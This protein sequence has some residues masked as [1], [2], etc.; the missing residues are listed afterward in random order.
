MKA[1]FFRTRLRFIALLGCC[2]LAARAH[3]Q[4]KSGV[5][6]SVISLP[7]GAGSIEGLG[8]SFEPQLNSGT[9]SYS[10]GIQVPPGVAG[11]APEIALTYNGGN[12]NG[13]VGI[14]WEIGFPAI[15][16]QTDKGIP[17]YT[18]AEIAGEAEDTFLFGGE[19]LVPL[20][21]GTYRCE[22]EASF[23]RFRKI[24]SIQGGAINAWEAT[25]PDGGRMV[26]GESA[27]Q[28]VTR[29][30]GD[31][32]AFADT[33]AWQLASSIDT[34]GNVIRYNYEKF[35]PE[36]AGVLYP[37]RVEYA[38]F[39]D[40]IHHRVEFTYS[41]DARFPETRADV[42]SDFRAGFE[43]RTSKLLR[44]IAVHTDGALVRR[45]VLGYTPDPSIEVVQPGDVELGFNLLRSLT[46]FDRSG[47]DGNYLPPVRF[48]YT[49]FHTQAVSGAARKKIGIHAARGLSG[50]EF[51]P[52][53]GGTNF[54]RFSPDFT[55]VC[56]INSDGLPDFISSGE[57]A[58]FAYLNTGGGVF[59]AEVPFTTSAADGTNQAN[60]K[61]L[62]DTAITLADL[63]GDGITDLFQKGATSDRMLMHRNLN[64]F[65][66]PSTLISTEV[67][68]W[69]PEQEFSTEYGTTAFGALDITDP[70]IR[71]IDLNFDKRTDAM[72]PFD[73]GDG[74]GGVEYLF[75]LPDGWT[76]DLLFESDPRLPDDWSP[77]EA[78][79]TG[80]DPAFRGTGLADLNGDRLIDWHT[81]AIVGDEVWIDYWPNANG[82]FWAARRA[83]ER[84]TIPQARADELRVIDVNADGLADLVRVE[85]LQLSYWINTGAD[86]WSDAI[87]RTGAPNY[88]AGLTVL[89]EADINGNG[90]YDLFWDNSLIDPGSLAPGVSTYMYFDFVGEVPPN[91]L[92]VI[93]NGIGLRTLI[94]YKSSTADYL[95]AHNA[96]HPWT[97]K[98][99]FPVMLIARIVSNVGLDLN[100]DGA[101]DEYIRDFTYRDGYYDSFEKEFRGFAFAEEIARGDDYD[102]NTGATSA[103]TGTVSAPS[104]VQRTRFMTGTPD[105]IDNDDYVAGYSGLTA[106]D[107]GTGTGG[108]VVSFLDDR[109]GREEEALKGYPVFQ[110]TIDAAILN[111]PL[112]ENA[113]FHASARA[114][115]LAARVDPFGAAA[116]R[117]APDKYVYSRNTTRWKVRRLYRPE[118]VA[119]PPGRF[120]DGDDA[121]PVYSLV[122]KSV[123]FGFEESSET[124]VI[125]ANALMAELR[126]G[127]PVAYGTREPKRTRTATQYDDYGN[128]IVEADYGI[129]TGDDAAGLAAFDDEAITRTTFA[130]GGAALDRW[131]LRFPAVER[132]ED[133]N[134]VFVSE[135][136][137]FYDGEEM[138]GL[139]LGEMGA[140][141][142]IK[143]TESVITEDPNALA[144][145]A[146]YDPAFI[147]RPGD[148]RLPANSTI[149]I[150][151]AHDVFGNTIVLLD[152]LGD[153][154]DVQLLPNA[155]APT[156]AAPADGSAGHFRIIEYDPQR[157][158]YAIGE[159]IVIG[160]GKEDLVTSATYDAGFGV[161]TSSTDFNGNVTSY[162]YDS[163]SRLVRMVSPGDDAAKPTARYAYRPGDSQ[164]NLV[165]QYG[166]DGTLIGGAPQPAAAPVASG[167]ETRVRED[168]ASS[169]GYNVFT[170]MVYASGAGQALMS[171]SED[172]MPGRWV[173]QAPKI[174]DRRGS[175]ASEPRPYYRNNADYH[176]AGTG[177]I[178]HDGNA[179][180]PSDRVDYKK[181]GIGRQI[182][183]LEPP[184]TNGGARL[185]S[186]A[187]FMPFEERHYDAEDSNP[188][189]ARYETPAVF[190]NDGR[191]R[192]IQVDEVTRLNDDGTPGGAI[193]AWATRYDYDLNQNVVSIA[194]SQNNVKW[195]RYDALGRQI[196][197][198]DFDRG[199]YQKT[200]DA[201]SNL[202]ETFDA[203]SQRITYTY[204][205]VNRLATED[206]HDEGLPFSFGRA[207]NPALPIG[208]SNQPDVAYYYDTPAGEIDLGNGQTATGANTRGALAYVVDLTGESHVSY[209][210]RSRVQWNVRR[211]ADPV[212]GQLVSF[213]TENEY[214]SMNRPRAMTYPDEDRVA[215][216]YNGR[217][218]LERIVGGAAAN[219]SANPDIIASV[220]F[221][222]S[223]DIA[224]VE[225]GNGVATANEFDPRLRKRRMTTAAIASPAQ[226]MLDYSYSFDGTSNFT[227]IDDARTAAAIPSGDSRR[228]TQLFDYD[229]LYRLTRA[230]Y[231]F[232]APGEAD[233][234]DG[235]IDYRYDRIGN[236]LAQSSTFNEANLD[237]M[238]YGG[239]AGRAGRIGRTNPSPGP[240]ALTRTS[241][242]DAYLYDAN[243]NMTHLEGLNCTWDFK[244][245]LVAIENEHLRAEYT[246]DFAGSRTTK[247]IFRARPEGGYETAPNS[248]SI[249]IDDAFEVRDHD[250]PT[251][252]VYQGAA[253][254]AE[255]TGT[256]DTSA[257]RVQR[258]RLLAGWNLI[259]VSV[260]A[261][262]AAAQLGIGS[263][264]RIEQA[265]LWNATAASFAPVDSITPLP[266]D[267]VLWIR[268]SEPMNLTLVG[269]Y[270]EPA[271][272]PI[273]AGGTF[274]ASAGLSAANLR[275]GFPAMA[276]A[277]WLYASSEADWSR[278]FAESIANLSDGAEFLAPGR[279]AFL[280]AVSATQFEPPPAALGIRYY[281]GDHVGSANLITDAEGNVLEETAFFPFGQK[282][283][284]FASLESAGYIDTHFGFA[285]K[286][287]DEE[288]G[289][290][291][292]EA[293][294]L[295]AHL[296]R[297]NRVEPLA[298][299]AFMAMISDPQLLNGYAY[300][301]NNPMLFSDP[302]GELLFTVLG[303]ASGY[304]GGWMKG[305]IK[306]AMA[307]HNWVFGKTLGNIAND[308]AKSRMYIKT[309]QMFG[310]MKGI[311]VGA[312]LDIATATAATG[313]AAALVT[314]LTA[315]GSIGGLVGGAWEGA[316]VESERQRIE[317]APDDQEAGGESADFMRRFKMG[318]VSNQ[319][320]VRLQAIAGGVGGFVGGLAGDY[321]AGLVGGSAALG[322]LGATEAIS[323]L[324][325]GAAE[326]ATGMAA[327]KMAETTVK[328]G[329]R[330]AAG[331]KSPGTK[332]KNAMRMKPKSQRQSHTIPRAAMKN[333]RALA[334][335][336]RAGGKTQK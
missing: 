79:F 137:Y 16:R 155:A 88:I 142:L 106:S 87:V 89:R 44:E 297:F 333:T 59:S 113:G 100:G 177:G 114:A 286:E 255:V 74:T 199:A 2:A 157:R 26:F 270:A 215:F 218:M 92:A 33:F 216:D 17:E 153:P 331:I 58:W 78:R 167:I 312:A 282:R 112:A 206:Y 269:S 117:C 168:I 271:P 146:A 103:G 332:I 246:Y 124:E 130:L 192:L 236:T 328:K 98:L 281:H 184:E 304:L 284:A 198:N 24:A 330:L 274:I 63:D 203:K 326:V 196:F 261:A 101:T 214:D 296:G 320:E 3:A 226:P 264:A 174:F 233:R 187:Q 231:S 223:G 275:L 6:P 230:Q 8:A 319:G 321:V 323:S 71:L 61:T 175:V 22:N 202:I 120:A 273:P 336:L 147:D 30:G 36:S 81:V 15:E 205:G 154:A 62:T 53:T 293:R 125:E 209:D 105:G 238:T 248:T 129:V 110:E 316:G 25:S 301:R 12:G 65:E 34:S 265:R 334:R 292:F 232:A 322:A 156:S 303:G 73:F 48:A 204:D 311:V 287:L 201:A 220:D 46:Q 263:D 197:M 191:G 135:N 56:D 32:N 108:P 310:M 268:A 35:E 134:G 289:L 327:K 306:L 166:D 21:D 75:N 20:S 28:R 190:H 131:L 69:G 148:P 280:R 43:R 208:G 251:K 257:Q 176:F 64:D 272:Q 19:E 258:Y 127:N 57:G 262:D 291:Y 309:T 229:D 294:Y 260:N 144:P 118:G 102:P 1:N 91:Q 39:S 170:R 128:A 11:H 164:R 136:R 83:M 178:R 85:H 109:G 140:R 189:S 325:G 51:L 116:L 23:I 235:S 249:Y 7:S 324:A 212:T 211:I 67:V 162:A 40:A 54:L 111:A 314:A 276:D 300:S 161:V 185:K 210:D 285:Q 52:V 266:P 240:H 80:H 132:V 119:N 183:T 243:G 315:A 254:V 213:K 278:Q 305:H 27:A 329:G 95:A 193:Q 181:D 290:H 4:G 239:F 159:R 295:A 160:D 195:F 121:A 308:P 60:G 107:E 245:R 171:V 241:K 10:V 72:R 45:Y 9:A 222:P 165:Y 97:T 93:D 126:N 41:G 66:A 307:R 298:G 37:S 5:S 267:S 163:F 13:P 279:A 179:L 234:N 217:G 143:R 313:G 252:F 84:L 335:H 138:A 173:V 227:R 31:P 182:E 180:T 283:N 38:R 288:S 141:G 247:K 50:P 29:A 123:S 317:T 318:Y 250:Q 70:S 172:E 49:R 302:D 237:A 186:I 225:Y 242:S 207:Y 115:A 150:R 133:E 219:L 55:E 256:F 86:N 194:D 99:P 90:T 139:P 244:D 200:F 299:G 221:I 122:E 77:D 18:A 152:S 96:G 76:G 277:A 169:D 145:I 42:F 47:G 151:A 259:S 82:G 253:L 224:R 68:R 228:N 14:G 188:A 149:Q 104:V 158:T 94:E